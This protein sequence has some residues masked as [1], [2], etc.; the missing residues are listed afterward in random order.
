M[1]P[2][3]RTRLSP[4]EHH[5]CLERKRISIEVSLIADDRPDVLFIF[6][7]SLS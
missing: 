4:T 6:L 1:K 5:V 3:E 2:L 7:V